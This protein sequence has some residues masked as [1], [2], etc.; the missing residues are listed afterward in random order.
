MVIFAPALTSSPTPRQGWDPYKLPLASQS[1]PQALSLESSVAY[2]DLEEMTWAFK[3]HSTIGG[4]NNTGLWANTNS[5]ITHRSHC[6]L[7][8]VSLPSSPKPLLS[9]MDHL[10]HASTTASYIC[11][12]RE[13]CWIILE[14]LGC[15]WFIW[16]V[17]LPV[18]RS[19][20]TTEC[21][22]VKSKGLKSMPLSSRW[23]LAY[24]YPGQSL[25]G[26]G[27]DMS[28]GSRH[29]IP[30]AFLGV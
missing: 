11:A 8:W 3:W 21:G 5:I 27:E 15:N 29:L 20:E 14:T 1:P 12:Y 22:R 30:S 7:R 16:T 4:L 13:C 25:Q 24:F 9:H 19:S 18:L 2:S 10:S 23:P 28:L 17:N 26:L 6:P